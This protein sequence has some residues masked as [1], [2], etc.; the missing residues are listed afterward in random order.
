M[1]GE[2]KPK[3]KSKLMPLLVSSLLRDSTDGGRYGPT[4]IANVLFGNTSPTGR[5]PYTIYPEVW[6][7]NT[8]MTDMS[9]VGIERSESTT[10]TD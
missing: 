6:A 5:L 1:R 4:A 9:L 10:L 3:V 8:E 2:T 7:K